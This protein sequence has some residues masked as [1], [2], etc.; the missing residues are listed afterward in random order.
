M[1]GG[2]GGEEGEGLS[3]QDT[4]TWALATVCFVFISLGI[5][6]DHLIHLFG[7]VSYSMPLRFKQG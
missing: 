3:L 5:F 7:R 6:I 2:G 1:G 4:P